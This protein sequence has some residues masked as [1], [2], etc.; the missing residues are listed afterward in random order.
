MQAKIEKVPG[1]TRQQPGTRWRRRSGRHPFGRALHAGRK[2]VGRS[3]GGLQK[4]RRT[5]DTFGPR[6]V[7]RPVLRKP[8]NHFVIFLRRECLALTDPGKEASIS[9]AMPSD[10]RFFEVFS[11]AESVSKLQKVLSEFSFHVPLLVGF[12]QRFNWKHPIRTQRGKFPIVSA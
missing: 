8:L 10:R 6:N 9:G 1:L 7:R 3:F 4:K 11:P 5:A 2:T 12:N